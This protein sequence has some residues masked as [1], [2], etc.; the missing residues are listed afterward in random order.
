MVELTLRLWE[1]GLGVA[2]KN[3]CSRKRSEELFVMGK[4]MKNLVGYFLNR[5]NYI[6]RVGC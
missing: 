3:T 6:K 2:N 1:G 5:Y 4:E